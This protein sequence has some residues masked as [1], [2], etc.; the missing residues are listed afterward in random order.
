M[1][2][3]IFTTSS[4]ISTIG[5]RIRYAM[6]KKGMSQA[7]LHR[8][9]GIKSSSM[10]NLI[11]G[12]SKRPSATNL[13]KIAEILEVSQPWLMTGV[14]SMDDKRVLVSDA[15]IH[16]NLD[17]LPSDQKQAIAAAIEALLL[18]AKINN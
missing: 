4:D 14:G 16:K 13:M 11:S 8:A 7:Q 10:S 5:D 18:T 6:E 2:K 15:D 12:K 9:M 17:M 3:V 1:P